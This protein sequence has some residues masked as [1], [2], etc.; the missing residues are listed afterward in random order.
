MSLKTIIYIISNKYKDPFSYKKIITF[1][2]NLLKI[3]VTN[4]NGVQT[5]LNDFANDNDFMMYF[6]TFDSKDEELIN[7][8]WFVK[9]DNAG[10]KLGIFQIYFL[11]DVG[12]KVD[13]G[14]WLDSLENE[15]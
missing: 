2:W 8:P 10:E 11:L 4:D 12:V 15:H 9:R 3:N 7:F 5:K 6:F 13:T 1:E 14:I